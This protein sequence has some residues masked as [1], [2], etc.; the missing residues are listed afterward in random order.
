MAS[1]W[2]SSFYKVATVADLPVDQPRVFRAAG[3]TVVIRRSADRVLAIDGSCLTEAGEMSADTRLKRV[4]ECVAVGSGSSSTE[5][6]ELH[7]RAGLAVRVE[8]GEVWVCID[9]C[10]A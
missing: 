5:W 6:D 1:P 4:L 2:E 3:A 9:G 10:G 7:G 8:D